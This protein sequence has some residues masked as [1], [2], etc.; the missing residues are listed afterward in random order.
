MR[1]DQL[2]RFAHVG[3]CRFS[4]HCVGH[5]WE[6]RFKLQILLDEASLLTCAAY[7][8]LNPIRAAGTPEG[9][10]REAIRCG[11]SWLCAKENPLGLSSVKISPP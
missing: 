6:D 9:L 5:F 3:Q 1:R 7:V 8:D 4:S 2:S 11:Q 10:A